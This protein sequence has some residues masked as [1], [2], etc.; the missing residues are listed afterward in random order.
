MTKPPPAKI[1]SDT[2]AVTFNAATRSTTTAWELVLS[3]PTTRISKQTAAI[4]SGDSDAL[5][6]FYTERFDAMYK[7]ACTLT[8]RDEAFC[9]DVVQDAMMKIIRSMKVIESE[10]Q[11]LAWLHA[12]IKSAAFDRLRKEKRRKH[13]E[14][15]SA[16]PTNFSKPTIDE[17]D[18]L[19]WELLQLDVEH[20]HLL[21][22]RMR[23]GWTL[24]RIGQHVGLSTGSVDGRINRTLK[25]L[26]DRAKETLQDAPPKLPP[27]S[28][29]KTYE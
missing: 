3:T 13:R 11:L 9:L 6:V 24:K 23:L 7:M 2:A 8:G 21:S 19:R 5:A 4:A 18:W 22:L 26:Q 29:P 16:V 10:P 27:K 15:N 25:N 17:F 1:L 28:T 14:R 20:A 12:V